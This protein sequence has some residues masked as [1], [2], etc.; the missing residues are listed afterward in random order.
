MSPWTYYGLSVL[1]L[2]GVLFWPA[3][4]LFWTLSVR[5]RTRKL[6]RALSD[7]ERNGRLLRRARL[8]A[9][10]ACLALAALLNYRTLE[11][12]ADGRPTGAIKRSGH[13]S[14]P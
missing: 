7:A 2:A 1:V 11:M 12:A 13:S 5:R 6:G 9:L 14:T 4:K 3:A 8:L 10:L